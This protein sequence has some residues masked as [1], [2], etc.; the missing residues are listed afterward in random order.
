MHCREGFAEK[1]DQAP[2]GSSF[3][4]KKQHWASGIRATVKSE[5][6]SFAVNKDK[7]TNNRNEFPLKGHSAKQKQGFAV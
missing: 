6:S 2:V 7:D 1:P 3:P 4:G 5:N